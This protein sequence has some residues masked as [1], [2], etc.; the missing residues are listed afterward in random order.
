MPLTNKKRAATKAPA[1]TAPAGST[2]ISDESDVSALFSQGESGLGKS[3]LLVLDA[4]REPFDRIRADPEHELALTR[5]HLETEHGELTD[6]F[7]Q[8]DRNLELADQH[9]ARA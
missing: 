8:I 2:P 7:G 4:A 6:L 3:R 5:L 9:L 1:K